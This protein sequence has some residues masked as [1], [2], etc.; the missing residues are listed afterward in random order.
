[1]HEGNQKWPPLKSAALF[2]PRTRLTPPLV[3]M[4]KAKKGDTSF[5]LRDADMHSAYLLRQRGSLAGWLSVTRRYC[6]KTAK[7]IF[8][9]FSTIW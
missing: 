3:D 2:E 4:K 1:M 5:L 6:I 7:P 8:K 9:T